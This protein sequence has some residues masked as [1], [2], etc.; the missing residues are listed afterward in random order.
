MFGVMQ[1]ERSFWHFMIDIIHVALS[2][3]FYVIMRCFAAINIKESFYLC[4]YWVISA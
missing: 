3:A 4:E 1:N 2:C